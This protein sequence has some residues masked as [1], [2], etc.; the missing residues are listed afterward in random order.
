[1]RVGLLHPLL[2]VAAF[3]TALVMAPAALA[4][5]RYASPT[6]TGSTCTQAAPCSLATALTDDRAG[7]A[8]V[9]PGDEIVVG[10]GWY[11]Y[12]SGLVVTTGN[13]DIH[14]GINAYPSW[15]RDN[16]AIIGVGGTSGLVI[17]GNGTRMRD[18][19]VLG[20]ATATSS[21]LTLRA[22][23][24][25]SLQRLNVFNSA[26]GGWACSIE[27]YGITITY[28][29]CR[30]SRGL[31]VVYDERVVDGSG[32]L[33]TSSTPREVT[34]QQMLITAWGSNADGLSVAA[35]DSADLRVTVTNSVIRGADAVGSV[36]VRAA[37]QNSDPRGV[38][39]ARARVTLRS[40]NF[41][42]R[43]PVMATTSVSVTAPTENLNQSS[44]PRLDGSWRPRADS[45][46]IDRGS[47]LATGNTSADLGGGRTPING[48]RDIG[49]YEYDPGAP[50][51]TPAVIDPPTG[52]GGQL[53]NVG[54]VV[55][56]AAGAAAGGGGGT[57]TGGGTTAAVSLT[58]PRLRVTRTAAVLRSRAT[59]SSAGTITQ[60]VTAR[61]GRRTRTVCITRIDV[62][63]AGTRTVSCRLTRAA[64]QALRR[65]KQRYTVRTTFTTASDSANTTSRLT[66]NRRR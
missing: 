51:A 13:L 5:V 28:A 48:S 29:H 32:T 9:D 41:R 3:A 31:R 35:L 44:D 52:V 19:T 47:L 45:P 38:N 20:Y 55:D 42:S 66:A 2:V 8:G 60:R 24:M 4:E 58:R 54:A 33:V 59:V 62:N 34:L 1:M 49:A 56:P 14:T 36:D 23:G 65:S 50:P 7:S 11:D 21:A 15:S 30:G 17:A 6:G 37:A 46:L 10:N 12:P 64:R 39:R 22:D 25:P 43:A 61:I 26:Q 63:A 27:G 40:S 18:L 16:S 57:A 53:G